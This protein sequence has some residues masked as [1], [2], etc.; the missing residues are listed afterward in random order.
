MHNLTITSGIRSSIF[1]SSTPF[2]ATS[3]SASGASSTPAFSVTT[4]L[5]FSATSTPAIGAMPTPTFEVSIPASGAISNLAISV[6]STPTSSST[7]SPA[8]SVSITP[9]FGSGGAIGASGSPVFGSSSTPAFGV[10][11]TPIFG[12]FSITLSLSVESTSAFGQ[13][14]SAF[15]SSPFGTTATPFG[16]QNSPFGAQSTTLRFG[17]TSI[18]QSPFGSQSWGSRVAAYTPTT[19]FQNG[20]P[21]AG[22]LQSLSAMPVYKDKSHEE[23]RW[24][25]YQVGDKGKPAMTAFNVSNTP[26]FNSMWTPNSTATPRI[27]SMGT[28]FGL[29]GA[30]VFGSGRVFG[31]SSSPV[32]CSSSTPAFDAYAPAFGA[33]CRRAFGASISPAS[34]ATSTPAFGAVSTP[35]F[36]STTT[37]AFGSTGIAIGGSS[38]PVFGSGGAFGASS[39]PIFSSSTPKFGVSSSPAFGASPTAAFEA[40]NAPSFSQSTSAFSS[41]PFSNTTTPFGAQS[42]L[43]A[44]PT[45]AFGSTGYWQSPFGNQAGGTAYTPKSEADC[46]AQAAGELESISALHEYK[47]KS[48]EELKSEDNQLRDTGGPLCVPVG[49]IFFSS[50]HSPTFGQSAASP[51][52]FSMPSNQFAPK[53]SSL[54]G[55]TFAG[56][57]TPAFS[58]SPFSKSTSPSLFGLASLSTTTNTFGLNSSPSIFG[59]APSFFNSGPSQATNPAFGSYTQPSPVLQSS[60]P[61]IRQIGST[62]GQTTSLG[63]STGSHFGHEICGASS[64]GF[65]DDKNSSQGTNTVVGWVPFGWHG[66]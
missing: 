21:T 9:V 50:S 46:S 24:V 32:I 20:A 61:T 55:L 31:G 3:Q 63:Q 51:F 60:T 33:F 1:G 28:A 41:S 18:Q 23:L 14:T 44:Q 42:S 16:V 22:N 52:S 30:P 13:S 8:F 19:E 64:T 53:T 57:A 12:S 45:T 58:S 15:G 43:G 2:G 65:R 17:G 40:F 36:G 39:R 25:D 54:G 48:H 66:V 29:S 27:G 11:T 49:G 56:S 47:D 34:G 10:S 6:T 5:S 7:S 59:S 38:V 4:M 35:A 62:F 37:P 26:A